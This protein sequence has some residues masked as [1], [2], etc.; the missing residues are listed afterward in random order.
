M[1][2]TAKIEKQLQTLRAE[3]VKRRDDMHKDIWHTESPVE[4]DFSE[5][6]TQRENDDVLEALD[7]EAKYSVQ[8]I[9]NALSRIK[10]GNYGICLECGKEI[11]ELRLQAM[12]YAE[13]CITCAENTEPN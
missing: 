11:S 3:Y 8:K 6:V 2:S 4:K 9:D 10:A 5:Q 12:P 7:D 1:S 13:Y